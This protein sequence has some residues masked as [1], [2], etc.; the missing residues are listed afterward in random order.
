MYKIEGIKYINIFFYFLFSMYL[1]VML[2][3]LFVFLVLLYF[4][5]DF[6][7][8][9]WELIFVLWVWLEGEIYYN[10][11]WG[12]I[13]KWVFGSFIEWRIFWFV[14]CCLIMLCKVNY[15]YG[16]NGNIKLLLNGKVMFWFEIVLFRI[17][18]EVE[19]IVLV[20]RGK[21]MKRIIYKYV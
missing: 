21:W 9:Y 13:G 1:E 11:N 18:F 5:Y 2:L 16:K 7:D 14:F 15:N 12:F 10:W 3:W 8:F 19:F 6:E 20:S 17:K 4:G